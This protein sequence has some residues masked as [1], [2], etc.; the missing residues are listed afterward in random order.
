LALA[1]N[2]ANEKRVAGGGGLRNIALKALVAVGVGVAVSLSIVD[3]IGE[4]CLFNLTLYL[5][6]YLSI[7]QFIFIC[8]FIFL[9]IYLYL[10]IYLSINFTLQ[11]KY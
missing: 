11:L 2:A 10:S 9:S 5:S 1:L 6:V 4:C 7:N 8:L 3:W